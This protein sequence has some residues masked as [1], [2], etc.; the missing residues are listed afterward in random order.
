[1]CNN[2]EAIPG[3]VNEVSV[4]WNIAFRLPRSSKSPMSKPRS[5]TPIEKD[6]NKLVLPVDVY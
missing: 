4:E 3:K 1:M 6:Q 5:L 2:A